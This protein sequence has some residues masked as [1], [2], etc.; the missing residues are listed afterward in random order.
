MPAKQ[1]R[2][3]ANL[4]LTLPCSARKQVRALMPLQPSTV[5]DDDSC[6]IGES[7]GGASSGAPV[8]LSSSVS[9]AASA[10]GVAAWLPRAGVAG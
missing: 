10:E 6:E 2:N 3:E 5:V 8:L 9:S 4:R 7:R 1:A